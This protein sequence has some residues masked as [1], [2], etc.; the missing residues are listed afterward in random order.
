MSARSGL[1]RNVERRNNAAGLRQ[2]LA[3]FILD[4]VLEVLLS[5]S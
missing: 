2:A 5:K 3:P 1:S 4:F